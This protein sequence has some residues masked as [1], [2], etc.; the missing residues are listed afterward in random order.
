MEDVSESALH[1]QVGILLE[2]WGNI[3]SRAKAVNGRIT[4]RLCEGLEN[5]ALQEPDRHAVSQNGAR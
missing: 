5:L 3:I 4:G 1:W 2:L